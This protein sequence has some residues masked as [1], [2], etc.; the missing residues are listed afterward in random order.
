MACARDESRS[1]LLCRTGHPRLATGDQARGEWTRRQRQLP[2]DRSPWMYVA[3]LIAVLAGMM[4]VVPQSAPAL[5]QVDRGIAG[6]RLNNT[7]AEVRAALG[8]PTS[9]RRGTNKFGDWL[10]FR[11]RGGIRVFFQGRTNVTAVQ[12]RGRG[13]RTARGVGVG[14]TE[15]VVRARVRGVRCES[16]FVRLCHT[17]EFLPGRRVTSFF[18]ERGRVTR[19]SV[20]FVID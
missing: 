12:L 10:E 2:D 14:S 11:F 16:D 5:I 9:V 4:L 7:Q 20:G 18:V 19:V 17:G 6:A 15:A 13:D 1:A 8:R 3:L